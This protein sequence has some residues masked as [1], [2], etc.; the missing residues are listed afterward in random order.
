MADEVSNLAELNFDSSINQSMHH[1]LSDRL[2]GKIDVVCN[3]QE[4][5]DCVLF[6]MNVIRRGEVATKRQRDPGLN[7]FQE[8]PLTI[9]K[10]LSILHKLDFYV[11]T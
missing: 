4:A 10:L 3:G 8:K 9:S 5:V 11:Q 7:D 6:L 2:G 1:K